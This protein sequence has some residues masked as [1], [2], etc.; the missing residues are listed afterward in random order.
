[1][2]EAQAVKY[3]QLMENAEDACYEAPTANAV[4]SKLD[5]HLVH[6]TGDTSVAQSAV[7]HQTGFDTGEANVIKIKRTV[8][9]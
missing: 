5:S 9:M 1:M 4:V 3:A 7:D 8:E 6:M 2:I